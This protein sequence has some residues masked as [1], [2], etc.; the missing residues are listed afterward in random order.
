M[1][2]S[3]CQPH[4]STSFRL[5]STTC[6]FENTS[7]IMEQ[8]F[9]RW[10]IMLSAL[11][12]V[13]FFHHHLSTVHFFKSENFSCFRRPRNLIFFTLI[14]SIIFFLIIF[15][16]RQKNFC[17]SI[18]DSATINSNVAHIRFFAEADAFADSIAVNIL[19]TAFRQ[20]GVKNKGNSI[21]KYSLLCSEG[22]D[23]EFSLSA[24]S[25]IIYGHSKFNLQS[26]FLHFLLYTFL[27]GPFSH[28]PNRFENWIVNWKHDCIVKRSLVGKTNTIVKIKLA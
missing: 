15:F 25:D 21:W 27:L 26:F 6:W 22:S 19:F 17:G 5:F 28:P 18:A 10:K 9:Q 20:K 2:N 16:F 14:F 23:H 13:S 1:K 3:C 7:K 8:K 24:L 12:Y 11:L 4:L